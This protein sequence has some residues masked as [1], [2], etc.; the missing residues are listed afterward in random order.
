MSFRP[1]SRDADAI[2]RLP[3]ARHPKLTGIAQRLAASPKVT[4]QDAEQILDA[5]A[6]TLRIDAL[7]IEFAQPGHVK[8]PFTPTVNE[9]PGNAFQETV[10][11]HVHRL[12]QGGRP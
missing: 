4:L 10:R 9:E 11:G 12:I 2:L 8:V 5:N 6:K 1:Q 3:A 7:D